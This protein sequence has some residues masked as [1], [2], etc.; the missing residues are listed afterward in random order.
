LPIV[1]VVVVGGVVEITGAVMVGETGEAAGSIT[2][3]VAVGA[4][5]ASWTVGAVAGASATG[6]VESTL[7]GVGVGLLEELSA[8]AVATGV[9]A[10]GV[11]VGAAVVESDVVVGVVAVSVVLVVVLSSAATL[12]SSPIAG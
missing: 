12:R 4:T 7:L 11:V 6:M 3:A 10:G 5:V 2:L 1:L 9:V 8:G